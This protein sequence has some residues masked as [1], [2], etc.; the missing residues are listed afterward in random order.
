[1]LGR[2]SGA[3]RGGWRV[4]KAIATR[5]SPSPTIAAPIFPLDNV[6]IYI[7][8]ERVLCIYIYMY[9]LSNPPTPPDG[10][11]GTLLRRDPPPSAREPLR[12]NAL[13]LLV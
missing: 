1:M 4:G 11:A 6:H 13:S 5:K 2:R 12:A 9:A 7:L 10:G 3:T 8:V